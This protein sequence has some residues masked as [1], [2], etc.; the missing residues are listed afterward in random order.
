MDF[1]AFSSLKTL[2]THEKIVFAM[3]IDRNT[4]RIV[5]IWSGNYPAL[6]RI[7]RVATSFDVGA[8]ARTNFQRSVI[9]DSG[10]TEMAGNPAPKLRLDSCV[11]SQ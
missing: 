6:W 10:G 5:W 4:T 9:F 11:R 2:I 7:S 1:T 8:E 3:S